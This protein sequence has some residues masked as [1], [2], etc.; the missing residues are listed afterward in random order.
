M[1]E[2]KTV[3]VSEKGQIA[4][5]ADVRESIGIKQ[6]DTLVLIQE[7]KG[8]L[9]QKAEQVSKKVKDEFSHLLKH[10]EDVAKKFWGTKAD[11]V[12]DTI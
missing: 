9:L 7:E 2:V 10:S 3:K 12:W 5:P 6:G 1:L 11:D 4:I 8:I